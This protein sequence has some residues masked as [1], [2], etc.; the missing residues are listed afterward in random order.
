M[1]KVLFWQKTVKKRFLLLKQLQ[2]AK[3]EICT[4]RIHER[5]AVIRVIVVDGVVIARDD[6]WTGARRW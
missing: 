1:G 6:K 3:G 2:Q 5:V 4:T